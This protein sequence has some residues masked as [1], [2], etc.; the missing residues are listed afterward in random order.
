MKAI[1]KA[2]AN[3]SM[4][5]INKLLSASYLLHSV[6]KN[7]TDEASDIIRQNGMMMGRIEMLQNK[8]DDTFSH[9]AR[10][11]C[12]MITDKN[13]VLNWAEDVDKI[14]KIIR[15]YAKCSEPFKVKK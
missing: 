13:T 7:L 4:E 12:S 5:R 3:G 14:E 9:Y 8:S 15:E 11:F 10:E 6:A 2:F 1:D